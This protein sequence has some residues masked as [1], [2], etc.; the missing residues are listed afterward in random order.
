MSYNG[1]REWGREHFEPRSR[2]TRDF[3]S[4]LQDPPTSTRLASPPGP[5][6]QPLRSRLSWLLVGPSHPQ[7]ET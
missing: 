7:R 2:T 3:I 4:Q 5:Q 6:P 1:C